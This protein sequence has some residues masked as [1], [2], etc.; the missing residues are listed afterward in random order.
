MTSHALWQLWW[1]EEMGGLRQ[2][3][4]STGVLIVQ[5][6]FD[7]SRSV[8]MC[9]N[10]AASTLRDDPLKLSKLFVFVSPTRRPN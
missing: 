9:S 8:C 7:L 1:L 4:P 10:S 2:N 6:T 5:P 3:S